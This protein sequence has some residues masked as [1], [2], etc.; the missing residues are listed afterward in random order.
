MV[1]FR[2]QRPLAWML[3]RQIAGTGHPAGLEA[4]YIALHKKIKDYIAL[5]HVGH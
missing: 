3:H 1:P 4:Q 2:P 5:Q